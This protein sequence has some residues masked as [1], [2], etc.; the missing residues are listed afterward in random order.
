MLAKLNRD[1]FIELLETLGDEADEVALRAARDIHA[2]ITVAGID[3]DALLLPEQN[4][5]DPEP[6]EE[7]E[8]EEFDED[9]DDDADEDPDDDAD[10]DFGAADDPAQAR[11]T[12]EE[13][14][15]ALSLIAALLKKGVSADTKEE[16]EGYR[17]DLDEGEF[18]QTDLKYLRALSRRLSGGS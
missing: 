16:L 15:E 18:E 11:L 9:P 1:E 13:R 14:E 8:E 3:W 10:G 7:D 17:E 4:G 12:G 5:A 6:A 2:R